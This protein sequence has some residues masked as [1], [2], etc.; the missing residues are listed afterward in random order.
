MT[1]PTEIKINGEKHSSKSKDSV[2]E[3]E[4]AESD[5]PIFIRKTWKTFI[6]RFKNNRDGQSVRVTESRS[7]SQSYFYCKN[8]PLTF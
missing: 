4:I 5:S 7:L 3:I 1:N 2:K 6:M 8:R